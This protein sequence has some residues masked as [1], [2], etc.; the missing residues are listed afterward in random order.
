MTCPYS[1]IHS[2]L[3]NP[4]NHQH[5][6]KWLLLVYI[7]H[8]HFQF[9]HK[10]VEVLVEGEKRGKWYG[11]MRNNKLVFFEGTDHYL[12]KL[13]DVVITK[14]SPWALQGRVDNR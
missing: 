4:R 13:V 5:P 3:T 8:S 2:Y 11:R 7:I 6:Q 10:K 9:Q 12:G 14:T 1:H